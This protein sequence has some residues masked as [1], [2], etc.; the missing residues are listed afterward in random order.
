MMEVHDQLGLSS[1][2]SSKSKRKNSH[3]LFLITDLD[4]Y[5]F[6]AWIYTTTV[7]ERK[8]WIFSLNWFQLGDTLRHLTEANS[9]LL[10]KK[11]VF[12]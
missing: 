8:P 12:K 4:F 11:N 5:E 9:N 2:Q 7:A 10:W 1:E 3:S 6:G